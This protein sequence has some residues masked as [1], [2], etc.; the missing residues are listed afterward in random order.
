MSKRKSEHDEAG[1][2]SNVANKKLRNEACQE[3]IS[4]TSEITL[5]HKDYKVEWI[6]ALPLEMAAAKAILDNIHADLPKRPNDDNNY[7]FERILGHNVVIAYLPSG[8]HNT[9]PAA[10]V[11]T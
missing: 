8:A 2:V 6:C 9:T 10:T 7:I 3:T 5:R 11:A 1:T 4:S